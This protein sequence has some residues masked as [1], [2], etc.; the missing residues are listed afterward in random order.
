MRRLRCG[1]RSTSVTAAQRSVAFMARTIRHMCAA[2][3]AATRAP[4]PLAS[5]SPLPPP[6]RI[7]PH[8]LTL[9]PTPARPRYRPPRADRRRRPP[10]A[11]DGRVWPGGRRTSQPCWPSVGRGLCQHW[12]QALVSWPSRGG[13]KGA[14]AAAAGLVAVSSGQGPHR[15]T[16]C[17]RPSHLRGLSVA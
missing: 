1:R 16:W 17:G 15:G 12:K 9:P 13:A 11:C 10:R 7:P 8:R 4:A 3:R 2:A 5:A 14:A 6:S